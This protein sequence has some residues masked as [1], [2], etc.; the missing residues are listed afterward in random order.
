M[1]ET[2]QRASEAFI[3]ALEEA[4]TMTNRDQLGEVVELLRH[5]RELLDIVDEELAKLASVDSP[6]VADAALVAR[7][8]RER[9][10]ALETT[11][12]VRH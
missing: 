12:I 7:A 9:L 5:A 2:L 1:T 11:L 3:A 4:R 10:A 8:M 6:V